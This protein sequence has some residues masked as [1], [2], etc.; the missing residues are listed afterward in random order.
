MINTVMKNS[1]KALLISSALALT[2]VAGAA[3]PSQW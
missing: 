3:L 2:T 1:A